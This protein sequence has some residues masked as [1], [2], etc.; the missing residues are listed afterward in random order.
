MYSRGINTIAKTSLISQGKL[1]ENSFCP[2]LIYFIVWHNEPNS[3]HYGHS[4][5]NY[6][7]VKTKAKNLHLF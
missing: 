3:K 1:T 2:D 4:V 5:L 7:K 6:K